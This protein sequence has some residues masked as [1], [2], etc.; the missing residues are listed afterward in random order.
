MLNIT[1]LLL[2]LIV[3]SMSSFNHHNHT[4]LPITK[5]FLPFLP[6]MALPPSVV[7][8]DSYDHNNLIRKVLEI[9]SLNHCLRLLAS[10][11]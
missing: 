11:S 9:T 6:S 1:M 8:V 3:F 5:S 10:F 4:I 7:P 2:L